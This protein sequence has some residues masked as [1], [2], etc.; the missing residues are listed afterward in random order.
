MSQPTPKP[1]WTM[2]EIAATPEA[3]IRHPWNP[4]SEVHMRPLSLEAGLSRVVLTLARVPPGKESFVYHAHERAWD[5]GVI[6]RSR[7]GHEN[8][9]KCDHRRSPGLRPS[10]YCGSFS[11]AEH[12]ADRRRA[13]RC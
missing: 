8:V 5:G 4:N 12:S 1:L 6:L 11:F 13:H 7:G 9:T 3:R 2:D 10:R